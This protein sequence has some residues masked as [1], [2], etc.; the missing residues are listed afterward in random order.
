MITEQEDW[1]RPT[2]D[3]HNWSDVLAGAALLMFLPVGVAYFARYRILSQPR[4]WLRPRRPQGWTVVLLLTCLGGAGL[5]VYVLAAW[6]RAGVPI[7]WQIALLMLGWW[8]LWTPAAVGWLVFERWR[9]A[10][11]DALGRLAPEHESRIRRAIRIAADAN[12]YRRCGWHV[13][14]GEASPIEAGNADW[15]QP[16]DSGNP[17]LGV[18]VETDMRS[19]LAKKLHPDPT[20]PQH[21]STWTT[22]DGRIQLPRGPV[23]ACI[24]GISGRG[25][26]V[27]ANAITFAHIQRGGRTLVIDAKGVPED[28]ESLFR[29]ALKNG[30]DPG[31]IAIWPQ[32]PWALWRGNVHSVVSQAMALLPQDGP[33]YY[34]QQE[35]AALTAVARVSAG[36][37]RTTAELLDRLARPQKHVSNAEDLA[38]LK[39]KV[40]AGQ[41]LADRVRLAVATSTSGL[42]LAED[43]IALDGGDWDLAIVSAPASNPA[44]S[45]MIKA[46]LADF[47]SFRSEAQRHSSSLADLLVVLDE[48]GAVLDQPDAP[49]VALVA[50]QVRAMPGMGGI[51]VTSQ[52]VAGLGANAGRLL[53]SGAT[54]LTTAVTDPEELS[55]CAGTYA[56]PERAHQAQGGRP[57]GTTTARAQR[58]FKLPPDDIRNLGLWRFAIYEPAAA[59]VVH[60]VIPLCARVEWTTPD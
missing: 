27:A 6:I 34:R 45:R 36:P 49:D 25:K 55:K 41:A 35:F 1:D 13:S 2:N 8:A 47:E 32:Q 50:E 7:N 30:V 4:A 39:G 60:A 3:D 19:P 21:A 31:R 57:T 33:S 14:N 9:V 20:S 10:R 48:A 17:V 58:A 44:A 37:W 59:G 15:R 56:V 46:V 28:A 29:L 42:R 5:A 43:G 18:V 53:G 26:S 23:R 16:T 54:I 40:G 38:T 24:T 22:S 11:D 12:A 51:V 52:S